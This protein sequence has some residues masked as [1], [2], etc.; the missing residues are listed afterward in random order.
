M[1]VPESVVFASSVRRE[2]SPQQVDRQ[3]D[4]ALASGAV[5][6][7]SEFYLATTFDTES[8]SEPGFEYEAGEEPEHS[9]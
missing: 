7:S 8:G 1:G 6:Y 4:E 2:N 9:R 3:I 5:Y